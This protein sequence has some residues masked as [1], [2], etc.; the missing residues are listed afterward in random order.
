MG[1]AEGPGLPLGGIT[2]RGRAAFI[3]G[4]YASKSVVYSHRNSVGPKLAGEA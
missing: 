1:H 4:L 2:L 3:A